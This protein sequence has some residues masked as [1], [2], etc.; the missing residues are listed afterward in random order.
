MDVYA[1]N[2]ISDAVAA[3]KAMIA[4]IDGKKVTFHTLSAS[5][6]AKWKAAA[7]SFR[8]Q[9]IAKMKKKGVDADGFIAKFETIH[10]KYK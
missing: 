6:E 9:W 5:E 3:K 2:Y 7:A 4:G 1:E 8:T 10:N